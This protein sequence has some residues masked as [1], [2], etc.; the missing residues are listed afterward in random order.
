[1]PRLTTSRRT[2]LMVALA[3]GSLVCTADPAYADKPVPG[4]AKPPGAQGGAD[5][6]GGL[7]AS[8]SNINR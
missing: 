8:V 2:K 5:G 6:K 7:F 4:Q 1:M 3:A